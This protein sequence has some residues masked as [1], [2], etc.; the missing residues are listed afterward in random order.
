MVE[1][2]D[3]RTEFMVRGRNLSEEAGR[4]S[5]ELPVEKYCP[6]RATL[7]GSAEVNFRFRIVEDD[8][9][10]SSTV[11]EFIHATRGGRP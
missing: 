3:I 11:H 8:A 7:D 4:R 1:G 5:V 9:G 10:V 2:K 6:V